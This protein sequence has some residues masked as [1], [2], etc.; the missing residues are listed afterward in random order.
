M[1]FFQA[2]YFGKATRIYFIGGVHN[3]IGDF[4]SFIGD[5]L[6]ILAIA[7]FYWRKCHVY[8]RLGKKS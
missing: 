1:A 7:Q 2:F 3:F 5:H 8:W 4:H 6:N